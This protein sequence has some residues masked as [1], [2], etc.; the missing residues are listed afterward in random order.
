M[1]LPLPPRDRPGAGTIS[2]GW[3]HSGDWFTYR[4][5]LPP[6]V[7][8]SV[9]VPSADPAAV[10]DAE[11]GGPTRITNYPGAAGAAEAVFDIASGAHEFSGPALR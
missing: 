5:E 3:E 8:A 6:N 9:R 1:A 11:G 4:V 10:R 7:T 2:A